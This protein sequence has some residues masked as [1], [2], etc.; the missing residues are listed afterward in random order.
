M[1]LLRHFAV[2]LYS[3]IRIQWCSPSSDQRPGLSAPDMPAETY[4]KRMSGLASPW[5]PLLILMPLAQNLINSGVVLRPG[6]IPCT[7]NGTITQQ[8]RHISSCIIHNVILLHICHHRSWHRAYMSCFQ[9][10]LK[11]LWHDAGHYR[12]WWAPPISPAFPGIQP[13]AVQKRLHCRIDK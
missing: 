10:R 4:P 1:E 11:D 5:G 3:C 2:I 9:G 6:Q 8:H 7:S 12:L 13:M